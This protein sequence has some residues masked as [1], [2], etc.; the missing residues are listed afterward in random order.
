MQFIQ[1]PV[2]I[3]FIGPYILQATHLWSETQSHKFNTCFVSGTLLYFRSSANET[4]APKDKTDS[5][6]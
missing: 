3:P 5:A 1:S 4:E 2:N 6:Y